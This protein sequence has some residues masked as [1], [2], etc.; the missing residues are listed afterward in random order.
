[1]LINI[2]EDIKIFKNKCEQ[3]G[4]SQTNDELEFEQKIKLSSFNEYESNIDNLYELLKSIEIINNDVINNKNLLK[5]VLN[6]DNEI[7]KRCIEKIKSIIN[8]Y[9]NFYDYVDEIKQSLQKSKSSNR[10]SINIIDSIIN[11]LE[12]EYLNIGLIVQKPKIGVDKFDSHKHEV[13][14]TRKKI[15]IQNNTIVCIKRKGFYYNDRNIRYIRTAKVI[16]VLN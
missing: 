6:E 13:I 1:M 16:T 4:S 10:N 5:N 8:A 12:K 7:K 9:V 2:C 3:I 11:L 15:N 14:D